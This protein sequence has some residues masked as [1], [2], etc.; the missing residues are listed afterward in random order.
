MP[1]AV[2]MV[3]ALFFMFFL[4]ACSLMPNQTSEQIIKSNNDKREYRAF[5]LDNQ[6]PV[7]VIS[8]PTADKAAAAM[9]VSVGSGSDPQE[10]AGL[11]HFLE[12]MLFLGTEKYPEP[13]EYQSFISKHGGSHNAFT[14][15]EDTNYFFEVDSEYLQPTLDRFAQFFISPLFSEEYVKREKNAVHSEYQSK[16]RDDGRR[17]FDILKQV[18]NQAH[19]YSKFSTGSLETL[20]D[21]EISARDAMLAFYQQHYSANRM[22]LV[23][24][25]TESLDEL[26]QLARTQFSAVENRQVATTEV[27]EPLF[28]PGS[29]PAKLGIK[30]LKARH[31]LKLQF[32]IPS[33]QE[34][35]REKPT[36][37]LASLIGHEGEGS[38]LSYLKQQGWATGLS[39]GRG[40]G[41]KETSLFTIGISLTEQGFQHQQEV[42]NAIFGYIQLLQAKG[43]EAW[44]FD[45]QR[46][47]SEQEFNFVEQGSPIHYVST[48]AY[49]MPRYPVSEILHAPYA[50]EQFDAKLIQEYLDYLQPKNLLITQVSPDLDTNLESPWFHGEYRLD[51]F[52]AN[53]IK[54]LDSSAFTLPNENP[55]IAQ[56]LH[57]KN[58]EDS[59]SIPQNISTSDKYVLWF[60]HDTEF[61]TPKAQQYFS[62]QSPLSAQSAKSAVMT[63]ML[64]SWLKEASN[65]F[66]YPA[67]LAGLDYTVYKHVRGLT[68]QL[69]GYDEKQSLLLDKLLHILTSD[70]IQPESFALVRQSLI[71]RW[72]NADKA[73]L[74]H[75]IMGEASAILMAPDWHEKELL[76]AIDDVT[77][78]QLEAFRSEFLQQLYIESM[79]V[80]NLTQEEAER[81]LQQVKDQLKPRLNKDQVPGFTIL[82]LTDHALQH[83]PEIEH[84][85]NA[86]LHYFQGRDNSIEEQARWMLMAQLLQSPYYHE[87]RTQQQLGYIVFASFHPMLKTPGLSLLVQSPSHTPEDIAQR[88]EAFLTNFAQQ[89]TQMPEQE[90]E[91]QKAGLLANLLEKDDHLQ[92]RT[93]RFWRDMALEYTDF[94]RRELLAQVVQSLSQQEIAEL[95]QNQL[96]DN[97][98]RQLTV[99][100]KSGEKTFTQAN[101]LAKQL[102]PM[103][104]L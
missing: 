37:Y 21:K 17:Q 1:N 16:L 96:V 81:N 29:L 12:H 101:E 45:E 33:T 52:D 56:N 43:I 22:S 5:V 71:K 10:F 98:D 67:K 92:A 87:M 79:I 28:T 42:I 86:Y 72:K 73:Q 64:A 49:N 41:T 4:T 58:T 25:G 68:L 35:F 13:G 80:G 48:L 59:R 3:F 53:S 82:S 38:L 93:Q 69:G 50:M 40:L 99:S 6:L 55:F 97:P 11:A 70:K 66:A 47:L 54:P 83:Q 15:Y 60:K 20:K 85:D 63:Q 103:D 88:S 90:F 23:I 2:R 102:V 61:E 30:P 65:E 104:Q 46:I 19:P 51:S 39:A 57:L 94:N 100:Y 91:Q 89:L 74:Y 84:N 95:F 31:E 32:P 26:E 24:L 27:T 14:S 34:Y 77:L 44:R 9:N 75:Q 18:L 7:I 62:L 8:D 76:A 78:E 36:S